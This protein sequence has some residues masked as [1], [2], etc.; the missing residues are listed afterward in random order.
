MTRSEFNGISLDCY[1]LTY[2]VKPLQQNGD[3]SLQHPLY[4]YL[5]AVQVEMSTST[6]SHPVVG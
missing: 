2:S 6:L 4:Y 3:A 1:S 5:P